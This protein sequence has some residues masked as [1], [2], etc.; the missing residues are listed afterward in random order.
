MTA[1]NPFLLADNSD[2]L[3]RPYTTGF[4]ERD[5]S[6]ATIVLYTGE[7]V[8]NVGTEF[9]TEELVYDEKNNRVVVDAIRPEISTDRPEKIPDSIPTLNNDE[10][11]T[12]I[13]IFNNFSLLEVMEAKDQIVKLHQN[14]GSSWNLFFFGDSPSIYTFR[15]LFLDTWEYPYYQEFMM[16]YDNYLAGRKCV[17]NNFK[18]KLVY[19]GKMVGGY[20][21]NINTVMTGETPHSKSFSF[22]MILTDEGYMRENAKILSKKFTG[23]SGFNALDNTHRVINQYPSLVPNAGDLTE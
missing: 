18:M 8:T 6:I 19:D 14:F 2:N 15:G 5:N 7:N 13:G 3:L 9:R 23:E 20:L 1:F 12:Y 4:R 11:G 16:M 21:M 17:E 22:T 10:R